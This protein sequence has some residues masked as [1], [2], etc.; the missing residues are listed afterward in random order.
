MM[1]VDEL[2]HV[3]PLA[4]V[5][6]LGVKLAIINIWISTAKSRTK[7]WGSSKNAVA[8]DNRSSDEDQSRLLREIQWWKGG[9]YQEVFVL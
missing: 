2:R 3:I 8:G 4:I 9:E 6:T 1:N 7:G 5:K